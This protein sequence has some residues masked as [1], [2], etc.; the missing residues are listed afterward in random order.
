LSLKVKSLRGAAWLSLRV[1]ELS[2]AGLTREVVLEDAWLQPLLTPQFQKGGGGVEVSFAARKIG[3]NLSVSG[4]LKTQLAFQCSRCGG[5][6]TLPVAAD[7]DVLFVPSGAD[8]VD[9]TGG[10]GAAPELS[11]DLELAE[12]VGGV[13]ELETVVVEALV[14]AI[15][16]YPL[17]SADCRG[18]C[19]TCGANL[20]EE[21]CGCGPAPAADSRWAALAKLRERLPGSAST[22]GDDSKK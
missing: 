12:I 17:C 20:K 19:G 2:D 9:L 3:D 7:L 16:A 22:P 8:S 14:L 6:A 21:T 15:P 10:E 4:T 13:A 5:D 18:R 11:G 1:D